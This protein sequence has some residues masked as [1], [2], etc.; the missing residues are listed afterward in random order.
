VPDA[1]VSSFELRLPEGPDAVLGAIKNL[2]DPTRVSTVKKIVRTRG[3]N[4]KV[5]KVTRTLTKTVAEP[6]V[7]PTEMTAQNGRVLKQ[8]T[9]ISVSGCV[10]AKKAKKASRKS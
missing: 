7:M 3:R 6:L 9:K 5:R 10:K 4:G 2:C 8:Q 1:P